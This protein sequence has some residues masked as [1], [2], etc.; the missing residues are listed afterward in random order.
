MPHQDDSSISGD[1]ILWRRIPPWAGMV[2]WEADGSPTATSQNFRDDNNEFSTFIE[3][4]STIEGVLE[5]LI[6]FGLIRFL[7]QEARSC[8]GNQFI[9]CRD[10]PPPGHVIICGPFSNA[11][12]RRF[13]KGVKWAW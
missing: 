4:E 11:V 12:G 10:E 7:A 2:V 1:M 3:S 5:G 8:L 9:F 6:G 13:K